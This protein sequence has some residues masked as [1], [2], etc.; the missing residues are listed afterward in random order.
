M[1]LIALVM[2]CVAWG[3]ICW[4]FPSPPPGASAPSN[5]LMVSN[6]RRSIIATS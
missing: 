5:P 2:S 6:W 4:A 1:S 3:D